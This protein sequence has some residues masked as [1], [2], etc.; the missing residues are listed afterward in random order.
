MREPQRPVPNPP[1]PPT[2][3]RA[4]EL[5]NSERL[6]ITGEQRRRCEL[7]LAERVFATLARDCPSVDHLRAA[8]NAALVAALVFYKYV[9]ENR[10]ELL[11]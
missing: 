2:A 6:E 4:L 3:P 9:G 11:P 1:P 7:A 5:A 8:A 10:P